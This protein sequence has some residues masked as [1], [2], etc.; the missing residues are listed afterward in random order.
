[1]VVERLERRLVEMDEYT[2]ALEG[3][4]QR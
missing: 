4:L 2:T 3:R 1:M